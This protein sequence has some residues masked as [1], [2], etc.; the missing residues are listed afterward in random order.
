[1]D[2][3][4]LK[5]Y[6]PRQESVSTCSWYTNRPPD[7]FSCRLREIW[8]IVDAHR[9]VVYCG[10]PAFQ[11]PYLMGRLTL[12]CCS[13]FAQFEREVTGGRILDN[14]GPPEPRG[15]MGGT[16]HSLRR[17]AIAVWSSTQG[18]ETVRG[19]SRLYVC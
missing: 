3:R 1:M 17:P 6:S 5:A 13:S 15:G 9:G 12:T 4:A 16:V 18:T 14:R 7:S 11:P 8:K 10:N 2:R 19:S